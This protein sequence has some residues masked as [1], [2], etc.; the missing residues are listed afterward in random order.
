MN[1]KRKKAAGRKID[2]AQVW[3]GIAIV[4]ALAFL[5][6]IGL[7]MLSERGQWSVVSVQDLPTDEQEEPMF[8]HPLTG[9][10]VYEEVEG[11]PRVFGVMI[12]NHVDAW[13]PSGLDSAFLV[14]EAPVEAGISRMLAFYHEGQ[15]VDEI[16][17][18]RSARP[19]FLD[20]NNELDALYVHVGGSNAALDLIA[21]GGT[22][23]MNQYWWG[24][25]FWRDASRF[26]PHNVYTSSEQ[27]EAF[28]LMREE[29]GVAPE[30][31][32]GLWEFEESTDEEDQTGEPSEGVSIDFYAPVWVV[33]WTW[34]EEL[35]RYRRDQSGE[36]HVTRSGD[37]I[38]ADNIAVVVT[39]VE[40]IDSVGR[41]SVETTGE[42]LGYVFMNG[43][44]REVMWKKPSASSRLRFYEGDEELKMRPGVT[45]VEV[46]ASES[47][48]EI[49]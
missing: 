40:I 39:E 35:G 15:E 18:V 5:I 25:Y 13:P 26:A 48:I 1:S 16:G 41:R 30:R 42:G 21:S 32:Y 11:L 45:W 7:V 47:A 31:V 37:Q 4:V 19:Y 28:G 14:V 23:D 2:P 24:D 49:Q 34:D 6:W 33:D 3:I 9:M 44:V 36:A 46:V 17:P 29:A 20:W 10:P 43:M 22:F 12:D 38:L 27:I 8:I